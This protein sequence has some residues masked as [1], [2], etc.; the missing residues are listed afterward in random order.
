[1]NQKQTIVTI[2]CFIFTLW[3]RSL[4]AEGHTLP[5]VNLSHVPENIAV[6]RISTGHTDT[7]EAFIFPSGSLFHLHRTTHAAFLIQH[8][9]GNLL[10][11]TGLGKEI[12]KQFK[13]GMKWWLKP[14]FRYTKEG[15]VIERLKGHSFN[16]EINTIFL[17]HLH[18][19]HASGLSDFPKAQANTLK[20]EKD[21]ALSEEGA[22]RP[23]YL[24][25]QYNSP[26]IRWQLLKLNE[27]PY[28]P[29]S[30]SIDIFNDGSFI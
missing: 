15:P 1:M 18:W 28:G 14:L 26:S 11:D 6:S 7:I 24:I 25:K 17:T 5:P 4:Q 12:D 9:Q 8:P 2:L 22:G 10:I 23:G 20:S 21:F 16:L 30:H 27:K 13:E 19:D 3:T 29:F